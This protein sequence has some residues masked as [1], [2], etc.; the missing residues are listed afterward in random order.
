MEAKTS[1]EVE[2]ANSIKPVVMCRFSRAIEE[3]IM[4]D[5]NGDWYKH[6]DNPN[7]FTD[8]K[9]GRALYVYG[10]CVRY[11]DDIRVHSDCCEYPIP[12]S[13]IALYD[14]IGG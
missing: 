10:D 11:W 8:R 3:W 9:L 12:N 2:T 4:T 13:K 1:N 6:E 14:I 7:C 5:I